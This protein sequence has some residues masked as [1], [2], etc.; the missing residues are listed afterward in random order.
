MIKK[1]SAIVLALVLCLSVVVVPASALEAPTAA[2]TVAVELQWDK[3]SYNPG[4][5]A[6]LSIFLKSSSDIEIAAAFFYIGLSSAQIKQADNPAADVK[7]SAERCEL[8]GTFYN[9]TSNIGWGAATPTKGII[10]ANSAD[11]AMYD[12]FAAIQIPRLSSAMGTHENSTNTKRGITSEELNALADAG[13]PFI[14]LSYIVADDV[15]P[16]TELK[17]KF[18]SGCTTKNYTYVNCT[19]NPGAAACSTKSTL[20]LTGASATAMIGSTAPSCTVDHVKDQIRFRTD[21]NDQYAGAFDYR[22]VAAI[23]GFADQAELVANVTEAGFIFNKGAAIDK[24]TA[25]AQ[26]KAGSGSYSQIKRA[27]ISTNSSFGDFAMACM[28]SNIPDADKGVTL[29]T[30]AYVVLASGDV[31]CFDAVLTSNFNTLYNT[32]YPQAFPA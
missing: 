16:G 20:D 27:H 9:A 3:A 32:Y 30:L 18:T 5:T 6:K 29:S 15:E 21:A 31:V 17:A 4:E 8:F 22:V 13:I 26:I 24:D 25:I 7:A 28:V 23:N 19:T 2:K 14:S 12:Q 1:I 11:E 10:A